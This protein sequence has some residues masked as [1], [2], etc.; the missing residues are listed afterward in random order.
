MD[1]QGEALARGD[2]QEPGGAPEQAKVVGL[3]P[4]R[5][6]GLG[7]IWSGFLI[8]LRRYGSATLTLCCFADS[9]CRTE[10]QAFC[11]CR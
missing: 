9:N 11:R 7:Q 4:V 8:A 5:V 3:L 10:A 6:I 2:G 1:V